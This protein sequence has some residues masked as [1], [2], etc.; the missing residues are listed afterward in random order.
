MNNEYISLSEMDDNTKNTLK[1]LGFALGSLTL[2]FGPMVYKV[3]S[4]QSYDSA[5]IEKVEKQAI[6]KIKDSYTNVLQDIEKEL[7]EHPS[8]EDEWLALSGR[9]KRFFLDAPVVEGYREYLDAAKDN[10]TGFPKSID[11]VFLN[12]DECGDNWASVKQGRSVCNIE[13]VAPYLRAVVTQGLKEALNSYQFSN[14]TI[15]KNAEK[16]TYD[17]INENLPRIF[18]Q[19]G[20]Y[21]FK[22]PTEPYTL[23]VQKKDNNWYTFESSNKKSKFRTLVE[24]IFNE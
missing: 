3:Q 10:N 15:K 4:Q 11:N 19:V 20:H 22:M 1:G 12:P 8:K 17:Y 7:S 18:E 23:K 2:L 16:F 21:S 13:F 6:K 9:L 14:D 5:Q 24:S